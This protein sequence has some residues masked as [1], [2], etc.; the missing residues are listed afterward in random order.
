MAILLHIES[1]STVC[2]VS[3]AQTNQLIACSELD[4]GYSHAE[5]LH[6]FINKLLKENQIHPSQ[7]S[8]IVISAGPGSYTGL[9][10]GF[11]AAKGLAYALQIPLISLDTLQILTHA[12]IKDV[13]DDALLCPMIDARRMEV[14]LAL[15]NTK[16]KTLI[17]TKP[18]IVTSE[19]LKELAQINNDIY[20]F[21]SGL[22]KSKPLINECIHRSCYIEQLSTS[23]RYM[24]ELGYEKYVLK[25]FVDV[26]YSE[27]NYLKD[28]HFTSSKK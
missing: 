24:I 7:L 8:A 9:R 11:S 15:F 3:L 26:A 14:Y 1:S 10:I 23:S 25:D 5:N 6:L 20:F 4:N 2:S 21:G 18:F 12:V 13:P 19:S 28:F 16:L 22:S 27:P 17:P